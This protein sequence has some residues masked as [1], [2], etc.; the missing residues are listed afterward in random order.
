MHQAVDDATG[1][2]ISYR[3]L[4]DSCRRV[5]AGMR[6]LGFQSGDLAGLHSSTNADL[7]VA[8]YGTVL[9]GGRMVFAKGNLTQ[10]LVTPPVIR[11]RGPYH[12]IGGPL[13]VLRAWS[14]V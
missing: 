10:R 1:E 7:I 4:E 14:T 9:A 6:S 5:A 11:L 13:R 3:Q 8:F 2:A 12:E